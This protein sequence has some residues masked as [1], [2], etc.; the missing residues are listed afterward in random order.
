MPC[1]V[2]HCSSPT[3]SRWG[4]LCDS[5]KARQRRH[6]HPTQ[7]G[8][9]KSELAHYVDFVRSR[10]ARNP[11]SPFWAAAGGRWAGLVEHARG[12]VKAFY[13]ERPMVGWEVKA[14]EAIV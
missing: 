8:V 9:S 11:D 14:C 5:H 10:K 12:V 6:G 2:P 1:R 3:S 4:V 13:S 7:R